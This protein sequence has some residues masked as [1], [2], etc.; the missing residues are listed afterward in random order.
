MTIFRSLIFASALTLSLTAPLCFALVPAQTAAQSDTLST[1]TTLT[2]MPIHKE[3]TKN[4]VDA[5]ASR[6][7]VSTTLDDKLSAKIYD[8]YLE[9]LDASKSY[10]LAAD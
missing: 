7:Y 5:L 1:L 6:H 4:I 3:T 2:A 8:S 10:F 9:D